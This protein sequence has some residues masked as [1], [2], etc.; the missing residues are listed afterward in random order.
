MPSGHDTNKSDTKKKQATR[1]PKLHAPLSI[2]SYVIAGVIIVVAVGGYALI[3][4]RNN[5]KNY[6]TPSGLK[7]TRNQFSTPQPQTA[8]NVAENQKQYD[9][10]LEQV[11]DPA[12]QA[13]IYD[14]KASDALDVNDY[15]NAMTYAKKAESLAPAPRT[16]YMIALVAQAN[17]DKTTAKKYLQ[18]AIDRVDKNDPAS[19]FQIQSYQHLLQELK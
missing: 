11:S 17:G 10:A 12:Q 5:P 8:A 7:E 9:A 4:H 18:T 19:K 15:T 16:A 2:T 14:Q 1:L 3:H 6:I 13:S